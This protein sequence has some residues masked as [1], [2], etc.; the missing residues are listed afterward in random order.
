MT[1]DYHLTAH[2]GRYQTQDPVR[3]ASDTYSAEN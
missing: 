3:K 1:T 2:T